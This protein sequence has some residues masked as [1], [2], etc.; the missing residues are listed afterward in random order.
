MNVSMNIMFLV[1]LNLIFGVSCNRRDPPTL[2]DVISI[3][4]FSPEMEQLHGRV[5]GVADGDTVT[6]LDSRN[7]QYRIRLLGIDAPEKGQPYGKVAKQVLSDRIINREVD[8]LVNGV[9]R[10]HR[11][12]GKIL[13]NGEDQNLRLIR[14]GLAWHYVQ[15]SK[16][17]FPGDPKVYS[18]AERVARDQQLGLWRES[19]PTP[20]WEWRKARKRSH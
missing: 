20:P 5:V 9:D 18:S 1:L 14:D 3:Q 2:S 4:A 19:S 16:T 7:Q 13:L 12:L 15:Y 10:Y 11:T 8:V 17:Q 6:I